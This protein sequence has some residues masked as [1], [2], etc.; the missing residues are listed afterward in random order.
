MPDDPHPE[1]EPSR[2]LLRRAPRFARLWAAKAVSHVGDG[3]ALVAL[4]VY[5]QQSQRRGVTVSLLL[6]AVTLPTLL[7]PLA[8]ALADRVEQRRL[9]LGAQAGQ[10][11]LDGAMGA[12]LPP[13]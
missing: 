6:L 7:G 2:W 4:V 10:A 1:P 12:G 3:A 11:V 9:M 13:L 5:V 8:G